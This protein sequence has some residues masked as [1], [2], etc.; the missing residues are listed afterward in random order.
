MAS[1]KRAL[2]DN[3]I[4][5]QPFKRGY[6]LPSILLLRA[7][8]RAIHLAPIVLL[9]ARAASLNNSIFHCAL[10]WHVRVITVNAIDGKRSNVIWFILICNTQARAGGRDNVTRGVAGKLFVM[11]PTP[12]APNI[13]PLSQPRAGVV[14]WLTWRRMVRVA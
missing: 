9:I 10:R 3:I 4:N 1:Y 13:A 8:S 7:S 11:L 14:L 2:V 6:R 12:L 5:A